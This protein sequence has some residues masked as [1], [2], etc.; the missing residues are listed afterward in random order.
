MR[1]RNQSRENGKD[2]EENKQKSAK[3]TFRDSLAA[4]PQE[5]AYYT[6]LKTPV[7]VRYGGSRSPTPTPATAPGGDHHIIIVNTVHQI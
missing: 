7:V 1:K 5:G 4:W 6:C 2:R 3:N